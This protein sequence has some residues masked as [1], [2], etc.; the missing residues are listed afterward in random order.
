MFRSPDPSGNRPHAWSEQQAALAEF[1][2][3][4]LRADDLDAIL[5]RAC[6]L[7]ARG[8]RAPI[9]KVAEALPGCDELLLRTAIGVPPEVATIGETQIPGGHGSAA[10]YTLLAAEP[11][12]SHIPTE[13]RFEPSQVVR[14]T[15]VVVSLNVLILCKD[16]AFGTLEV[17]CQEEREFT[18][19]DIN[20]LQ[21]YANLLGAAVDRHRAHHQLAAAAAERAILLRE[22][23]HRTQND[24]TVV[25]S[26]LRMEA[27]RAKRSETR[28]RLETVGER[29]ESLAL[30]YRRLY[31]SGA[32]HAVDLAVYLAELVKRRF[33]MHGHDADHD[34]PIKLDLRLVSVE[35]NHD[36][37]VAVGLIVNELVTNSLKYAFPLRRG[38]VTVSLE[39]IEP[40]KARLLV[41]DDG[42]GMP[43]EKARRHGTGLELI[44]LLTKTAGG[45]FRSEERDTGTA[46]ILTFTVPECPTSSG[47]P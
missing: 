37:A 6:E 36:R 39:R 33:L 35:V 28:W 9:A 43:A 31:Q 7:V 46:G 15:S 13:T 32:T 10:G 17:D 24:L 20:F 21:T 4:A 8:L 11:V 18:P 16:G 42:I 23:Q 12:I 41:A 30:I 3:V 19:D 26:L 45:E 29:V 5:Q 14:Q 27:R 44:P 47:D 1:G 25:T 40:G 38:T 34:D 2:L 22:L